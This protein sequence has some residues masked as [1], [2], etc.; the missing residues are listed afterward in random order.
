[1]LMPR[2]ILVCPSDSTKSA[3]RKA[4][5]LIAIRLLTREEV[6]NI[7][8]NGW[9]DCQQNNCDGVLMWELNPTL[10]ENLITVTN[11]A[12]CEKFSIFGAGRVV[13]NFHLKIRMIINVKCIGFG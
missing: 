9:D 3:Y 11:S 1:M 13:R 7:G 5:E 4:P 2:G 12:K 8:V 6:D 10:M